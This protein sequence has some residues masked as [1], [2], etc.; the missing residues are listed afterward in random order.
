MP[1]VRITGSALRRIDAE[2]ALPVT[3][4]RRSDIERSGATTTAELLQALPQ[5]Q[6]GVPVSAVSGNDTRGYTSV[7]IHNL[8]DAYTLVLL[9]GQRVAPFGGQ[10]LLGGLSGVDLNTLPL[11]L[12]ERI[13]LLS[14]GASALYGADALGG[15]V[16]IITRRDGQ[17]NEATLGWTL[18]RGGG[19]EWRAS[20]LKSVGSLASGGQNLSLGAAVMHRSPLRATGRAYAS[21]AQLDFVHQ[22]QAYR[23]LDETVYAAPANVYDGAYFNP[24]VL[25]SGACPQGQYRT[26]DLCAY[27]FAADL[28]LVPEQAQHSLMASYTRQIGPDGQLQLDALWSRSQVVSHLSPVPGLWVV[29]ASNP[30]YQSTLSGLGVSADPVYALARLENL[31]RRETRDSSE[32]GHLAARLDGRLQGWA[33]QGGLNLSLSAQRTRIAN[34]IGAQAAQGLITRNTAYNPFVPA[35]Q[36]SPEGVAAVQ[37]QAYNGDWLHGRSALYEVQ[38]QASR[39][40]ASLPGGDVKWGVGANLRH[41]RL[42]LTPS[43][44]AQGRLSDP[45]AGTEA[46]DG[47][48]DLRLG[49]STPIV[50]VKASRTMLGVFTELLAPIT[51]TLDVGAALRADHDALA[52]EAF[53]GKAH[54]RWRLAPQWLLGRASVGTGFKT[55]S[56]TQL[57][58]PLQSYGVTGDQDC[59]AA[60]QARA[61]A[62]GATPC[63][64]GD[65]AA[66]LPFVVTGNP[67]LKPERSLQGSVGLRVEPLAGH[68]LGVD[69]WAVRIEDRIGLVSET[70]AFA[71]PQA[72]PQAWAAVNGGS[73]LAFVGQ[74]LNLG[75]LMS[76]GVD[77]E[78]SVR[79]ASRWGLFDSQLRVSGILREVGQAYPGG[80]WVR[81]IA[82]GRDGAATLKW[83]ASWRTSFVRG[84][85]AH[86][87]TA[88]YQSG[89]LD[90]PVQAERLDASGQGT[91]VYD[92]LRLKAPGQLLW[93]WQSSWQVDAAWQITAGVLNVFNTHPPLSLNQTGPFKAYAMGYDERY[94]DARGRML[95]IQARVSF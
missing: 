55:P 48:G 2:T 1:E 33:W 39:P 49:D 25:D 7:S 17:A 93:D 86:S 76:T 36:Q 45:A 87:L 79:R 43:L 50:P 94:F 82:D 67:G 68:S 60:L 8:G 66:A 27:N 52:G 47:Q 73:E 21:Q 13:E 38:W 31:G 95:Q 77:V 9:N 6:G 65:P 35:A 3:V 28:D 15:V 85:W 22:G 18:P 26:G 29:P 57:R 75:T 83:R 20:A 24:S 62:V 5:I 69:L 12:I 70:T 54:A 90:A 32:L 80:P 71:N 30:A 88:R 92:T 42:A 72:F 4:L 11:A 23:R 63:V 19:R 37:S 58:A 74:P 34:A 91:G 16:N 61:Q 40:V 10:S 81:N 89:Y 64:L 44:F 46:P 78:G 14:D 51:P 53:T 84:G 41:E 56:L 59:T